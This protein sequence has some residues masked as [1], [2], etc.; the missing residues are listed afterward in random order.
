MVLADTSLI[1]KVPSSDVCFI[2]DGS[3]H[4]KRVRQPPVNKTLL[5]V[6]NLVEDQTVTVEVKLIFK[7]T[8]LE[9]QKTK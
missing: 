5:E 8:T 4:R 9:Q 2:Y 7:N 3:K 6:Q 1:E